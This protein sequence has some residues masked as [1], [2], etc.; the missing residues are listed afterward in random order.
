MIDHL[1]EENM[2]FIISICTKK[3]NYPCIRQSFYA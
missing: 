1:S 3:E 2:L